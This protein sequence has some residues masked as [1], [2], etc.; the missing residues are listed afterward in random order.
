MQASVQAQWTDEAASAEVIALAHL[1]A[2]GAG[3]FDVSD[4]GPDGAYWV[5]NATAGA[6]EIDPTATEHEAVFYM[7][8]GVANVS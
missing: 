6:Y 8:G 7:R 1:V 2:N 4:V 3:G 5:W